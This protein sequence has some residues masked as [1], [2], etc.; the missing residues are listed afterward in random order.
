MNKEKDK[1]RE[2]NESLKKQLEK[3]MKEVRKCNE[4]IQ[5]TAK[6]VEKKQS[7]WAKI[8]VT[9]Q[10]LSQIMKHQ[11]KEEDEIE[12]KIVSV[13]KEKKKMVRDTVDKVKCV[14]L[15]GIKED[16]IEDRT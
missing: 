7:E 15:F 4:E 10:S 13:I 9:E 12:K 16:N 11:K 14:V 1:L 8:K 5:T 2:E 6:C 3:E